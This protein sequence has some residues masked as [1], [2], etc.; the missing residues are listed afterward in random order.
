MSFLGSDIR[1][2][3]YMGCASRYTGKTI[4]NTLK[5][6][7]DLRYNFA[8]AV[9][10]YSKANVPN[11]NSVFSQVPAEGSDIIVV[12]GAN[13]ESVP[14]AKVNDSAKVYIKNYGS[15]SGFCD[16]NRSRVSGFCPADIVVVSDC[17]KARVFQISSIDNNRN[18]AGLL[19]NPGRY[20]PGNQTTNWG[21]NDTDY[22]SKFIVGAEVMLASSNA[23][24]IAK[25]SH[26]HSSLWK[27]L[28]GQDLELLEGVEKLV[29]R[30]GEDTDGLLGDAPDVYRAADKVENWSRVVSVE[31]EMLVASSSDHVLP[32]P[33]PY[34]F[35]GT[36]TTPEDRRL[37][38]VFRNTIGIRSRLN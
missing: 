8:E 34:T 37:R 35:N 4:T 33:Q 18:A 19:H 7:T 31:V 26:A 11:A 30:Y 5:E 25:G 9:R 36:T 28:N 3:G 2:A 24:Y 20:K 29:F 12:R 6:A 22:L 10:G 16:E 32:D 1:M 15:E 13:G 21:S 38:R 27:N 23:F 17:T 14:V